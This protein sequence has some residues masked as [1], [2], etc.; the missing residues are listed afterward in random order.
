M[1]NPAEKKELSAKIKQAAYQMG[2]DKVGIAKAD[3]LP[4]ADFLTEW[5]TAGKHGTMDWM[6]RNLDKRI[7]INML[8]PEAKSVISVAH[9][10]YTRHSHSGAAQKCKISRYAWGKDY[11]KII[12]KKLKQLLK[13]IRIIDPQ[14][15]GRLFV[16]TAPIQDKLWAQQAGI[17]WQG[18]NTNILTQDYGSWIFLGE[19]VVDTELDYDPAAKD[20]CGNCSACIEAC[21][22]D[23]LQLYR[24]DATKCI[25]YLTI[26]YWD[27]PIPKEY[28]GKMNN[29]IFGCDIC[30]DVC[31]WNRFANESR[32][33]NY[34][35]IEGQTE[36]DL[37]EWIEKDEAAFRR[38]FRNTPAFRT[39][40]QNLIRNIRAILN[41]TKV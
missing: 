3:K 24:I 22:T 39:G 12:K 15:N 35:P 27:R 9:N 37:H 32:E 20:F 13:E 30:Q 6:R 23:A 19:L 25:S 5:I 10:Y 2:F 36:L 31:P 18:K 14:I 34:Q 29:W 17:G 33:E 4:R 11:H 1:V 8:Y 21:P 40:F 28:Q 16:D 26:E 7:D 38:R 41:G